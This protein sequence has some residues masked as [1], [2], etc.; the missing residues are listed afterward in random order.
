[1]FRNVLLPVDGS[2]FSEHAVPYALAIA[3]RAQAR[4]HV[5]LVHTSAAQYA[6]E[7]ASFPL[8]EEWE[9]EFRQKETRYIDRLVEDMRKRGLDATAERQEGDVARRII[10]RTKADADLLV[11]A[12]HGRGGLER[13]WLGSVT[14][15]V[16]HHV[17]VPVLLVE[18]RKDATPP[19]DPAVEHILVATDGSKAAAAATDEALR[20]AR[21][22]DARLTLL[23][24]VSVPAG[25]T[26]PYI[27][28]A[29]LMD[30]EATE[31]GREEAEAFLAE[32]A[33][34]VSNEIR[35]ET[36]VELAYHPAHVILETAAELDC[37]LIA[38]GTHRR[39]RLAR[40]FLGSVADKVVRA[41]RLPVLIGHADAE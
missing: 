27:P 36:R 15:E 13:A 5:L 17:R 18:P 20:I 11:M 16:V 12:T 31:R 28:H 21:L 7:F 40:V 3:R 22:F 23:R 37:D 24:V 41:S 1:M 25:L 6:A 26:S 30:R 2:S 4:I 39:A 38:L 8:V 32:Q 35:V 19:D 9:N 33:K 10:E 34:V 29:A 14:D